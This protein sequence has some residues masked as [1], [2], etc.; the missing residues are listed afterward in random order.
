MTSFD[1]HDVID[2]AILPDLHP[3]LDRPILLL[4]SQLTADCSTINL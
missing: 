2:G 1:V 4:N 3:I